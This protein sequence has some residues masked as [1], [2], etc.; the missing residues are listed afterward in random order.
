MQNERQWW[1]ALQEGYKLVNDQKQADWAED[2]GARQ[3][4]SP[5]NLPARTRW[6]KDHQYPADDAPADTKKAYYSDLLK[7]TD[8]WTRERPNTTFIWSIRLEAL[9]HL[10]DSSAADLEAC[11]DKM[12]QV[13]EANAGPNPLDSYVY[14]NAAE[15]LS[16]KEL[17]PGRQIEMARK[18][19][20][21][22]EVEVKQPPYDLYATKKDIDD[23]N[24]Y[25]AYQMAQGTFYEA[26]AQLRLK[27]PDKAQATLARLDEKLQDLKSRVADKDDRRKS[28]ATEES[29]YWGGTA[30]LAELQDRKLD[31][32]AY[33][34]SALLARLDSGQIPSAGEKD[35]LGACA[36]DL[37]KTLGGTEEG[38]KTWYGRR[39]D[40]LANQS[41]LTW[42]TASDPLPPFQLTDLKGRTWQVADLKG[43][44][45]FLN[46][47]ASW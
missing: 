8:D 21:R 38:W 4:P 5:Y 12:L 32:M 13:A 11:I 36:R 44:V 39:A 22:L 7:Q 40:A 3:F 33:Y 16:K 25:N 18:G 45:V 15:A 24:F 41:H 30:R 31:A 20:D 34:E 27:E 14:F 1:D 6:N 29:S 2:E 47:W 23:Q 17:Q 10:D 19:I 37:W 26:D 46:F 43:K 28:Y 35:E 42:E 9:E